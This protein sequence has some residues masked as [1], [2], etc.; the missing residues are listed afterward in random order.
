MYMLGHN[1]I[2]DNHKPIAAADLLQNFEKQIPI[3]FLSQQCTALIAACGNEMQIS[4][5][6]I[7]MQPSGH[8]KLLSWNRR[9]SM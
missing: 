2:A 3:L 8:W 6:V 5:A 4:S 7:T 9:L 1:H